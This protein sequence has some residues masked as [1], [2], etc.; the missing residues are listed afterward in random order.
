MLSERVGEANGAE[1]VED[2]VD[3]GLGG[4]GLI[5]VGLSEQP[6]EANLGGGGLCLMSP[7]CRSD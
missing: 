2:V 5:E 7:F 3:L 6:P 4:G 1:Q